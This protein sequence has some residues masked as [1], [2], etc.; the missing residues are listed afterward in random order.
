M[1]NILSVS[2]YV[3]KEAPKNLNNVRY[4]HST[5][6]IRKPAQVVQLNFLPCDTVT[7]KKAGQRLAEISQ[8]ALH[9]GIS[10]LTG[11]ALG[12]T[13]TLKPIIKECFVGIKSKEEALNIFRKQFKGIAPDRSVYILNPSPLE[14]LE[15]GMG[16][17]NSYMAELYKEASSTGTILDRTNIE[18]FPELVAKSGKKKIS[19]VV[20]DDFSGSG[21]SLIV[22]TAETLK[23]ID[24]PAGI[25]IELVYSPMC[26]SPFAKRAFELISKNDIEGLMNLGAL[27]KDKLVGKNAGKY[28]NDSEIMRDFVNKYKNRMTIRAA[29]DIIDAKPYYETAAY[30]NLKQT[31]PDAAQAINILLEESGKGYGRTGSCGTM[32]LVPGQ[33]GVLKCPNNN[34]EGALPFVLLEGAS[35]EKIKNTNQKW[36]A[37]KWQVHVRKI[38]S[39][40][41][42]T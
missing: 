16:T 26:A 28:V 37:K 4:I 12:D 41:G 33:D 40:I 14:K 3:W 19:I 38:A 32:V 29:D 23:N 6:P 31:N 7:I 27:N 35:P 36:S 11:K 20:P 17:S 10:F 18:K 5:V 25:D 21:R 42:V 34:C 13:N 8:T 1:V 39:L 22:N 24:I 9:K 15:R 2:K 30:T